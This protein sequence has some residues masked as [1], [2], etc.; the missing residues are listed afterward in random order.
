[1]EI[2][3]Y[4]KQI[5]LEDLLTQR[6]WTEAYDHLIIATGAQPFLPSLDGI[7]LKGIFT[8]RSIQDSQAIKAYLQEYQ[9]TH[10]VVVGAGYIGLEMV[11]NLLVHGCKVRVIE[12]APHI[13]PN[14]DPDLAEVVHNY[15]ESRGI[16]ILTGSAPITFKG[17]DKVNEVVT[18]PDHFP[19]D[20]VILSTGVLPNSELAAQTGIKLGAGRAIRV[21]ERMETSQADIYAAGDCATVRHLV[22]GQEVYLPMGTTASKQGRVA[23]EN[24]AGGQ[25]ILKGVLG[26]GIT[27]IMEMEVSRTG[28]CEYEC[29][30]LGIEYISHT[31]KSR[32]RAPYLPDSGRIYVKLTVD[33]NSR[34]LLGGQIVGYPGAGKRIDTIA[35]ALTA[36]CK[37]DDLYNL[38]LAYTPALSV[39][40]DPVLIAINKFHP[41]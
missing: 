16:E 10:A 2:N 3:S 27:R 6:S 37:I 18:G 4:K 38:D 8:L 23:G 30:K 24:A 36:R 31:I 33:K 7:G 17:S 39:L 41:S 26:T 35:A 11:E 28:L 14:M 32:T 22:S 25:A 1:M 34:L 9:P 40:S 5:I 15:M 21:N 29:Q 12:K 13:L 19:A 20:V